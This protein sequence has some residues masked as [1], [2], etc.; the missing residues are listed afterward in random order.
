MVTVQGYPTLLLEVIV[1]C[2]YSEEFRIAVMHIYF[3]QYVQLTYYGFYI[4]NCCKVFSSCMLS[5]NLYVASSRVDEDLV[6]SATSS[7]DLE[8]NIWCKLVTI[9]STS[10][11]HSPIGHEKLLTV[12]TVLVFSCKLVWLSLLSL[13]VT[14]LFI[15]E[16][17]STVGD[18]LENK[19]LHC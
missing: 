7:L 14:T 3:T 16:V 9:L 15:S 8:R 18:V 17:L 5:N 2:R 13:F 6:I 1:F 19:V 4:P 11:M 12:L 10:E